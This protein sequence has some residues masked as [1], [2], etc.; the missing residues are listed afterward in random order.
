MSDS[1]NII[2]K[3]AFID[4]DDTLVRSVSGKRIPMPRSV[5][6][7]RRLHADGWKLYCWS[8]GGEAYAREV[9]ADLGLESLFA[10]F[11]PKPTLLL[12]DREPNEWSGLRI[13]HPNEL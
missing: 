9:A 13:V 8:A 3:I 1:M 4:V 6:E 5:A 10:G 11:L 2:N 12:D 7:V